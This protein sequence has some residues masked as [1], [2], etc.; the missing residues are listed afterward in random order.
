MSPD[1][2]SLTRRE[3]DVLGCLIAGKSNREIAEEL[4]V[5][6]STVKAHLSSLYR[7]LGVSS[8]VQAALVGVWLFPMLRSLAS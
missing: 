8:R 3:V 1:T 4:T 5:S 6:M 2:S 7:K